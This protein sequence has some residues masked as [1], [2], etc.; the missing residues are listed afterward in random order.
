VLDKNG[1]VDA[2]EAVVAKDDDV[3]L[4][5]VEFA[6]PVVSTVRLGQID[7]FLQSAVPFVIPVL[8]LEQ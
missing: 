4:P 5:A 7:L 2:K 3:E 8:L 1:P 6:V